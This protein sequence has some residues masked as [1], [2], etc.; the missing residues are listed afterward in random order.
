M[1][2]SLV[3]DIAGRVSTLGTLTAG[4]LVI[5]TL[6]LPWRPAPPPSLCGMRGRSC[7]PAG[8]YTLALHDTPKHPHTW[9]LVNPTLGV[10]HEPGDVPHTAEFCRTACLIHIA[11]YPDELEG[12]IGVGLRRSNAWGPWMIL[13]SRKAF[14]ALEAALPWT[15][16]HTLTIA[17][18][19]AIT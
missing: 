13:D 19:K 3:R 18:A 11:N 12:C 17:Y 6:E 2:L 1:H 15:D 9:A 14:A 16:D 5:Q 8:D 10:Y 4:E 7:L